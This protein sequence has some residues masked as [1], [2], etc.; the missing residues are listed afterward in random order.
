MRAYRILGLIGTLIKLIGWLT[1][2]GTVLSSC[3]L[4]VAGIAGVSALPSLTGQNIP[5]GGLAAGSVGPVIV[6]LGV[7]VL[8]LV[9]GALEIAAGELM[10]LFIDLSVNSQRS[11][12]LLERLVSTPLQP[13]G[14]PP[15]AL[16]AYT[17]PGTPG[18]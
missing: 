15:A 11:V 10:G 9:Y 8:G 3:G 18:Q 14:P 16:A 12:Q 2:I 6:S 17:Q 4:L 13:Q 1:V 7:L 5:L